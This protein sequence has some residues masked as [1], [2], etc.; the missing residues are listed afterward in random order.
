MSNL[1][2]KG[3]DG[4]PQYWDNLLGM[5]E[6]LQAQIDREKAE[7]EELLS[8]SAL[9]TYSFKAGEVEQLAKFDMNFFAALAVPHMFEV[10]YPPTITAIWELLL[11]Q[12]TQVHKS[13]KVALGIPRG[14]AKTTLIKL[15]ILYVVLYTDIKFILIIGST[16]ANAYN[17]IADVEDMLSEKNITAT[18]GDWEIGQETDTKGLKKFGYRG[19]NIVIAGLGAGGSVRGINIKNTRPDLMI[20]EDV[21]TKECAESDT[22]SSTLERWMI[23]TAMKARAPSG[24]LYIFVGNMYPGPNSI[25]RKLKAN[26]TWI[27]F[28]SGAILADGTALFPAL[29]SYDSLVEELNNDISMGHPEIFFSEVMNDVE[30]GINSNTDLALIRQWPWQD[31]EIPQG[32]FI[33]I[34]PASNRKG[35]DLV[36][37][38]YFEVYDGTPGMKEVIEEP[39]SPGNTIRRALL[40]AMK[41]KVRL[42]AVESTAYQYSL[43]YWF[44]E[45]AGQL[46]ISGISFVEVYSGAYSKNSRI[47]DTLK[48][49]TQ[50]EL[51][52]HN[53]VRAKV[54]NQI[55]NWNPLKRDNVD[56]ILDLL[57]YSKRVM[58]LYGPDI[59]TDVE[60]LVVE[61]SYGET[62][63]L[64]HNSPF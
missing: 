47:Q 24:C 6:D 44:S 48:E 25:L 39:L 13:P 60:G 37:I 11:D 46:G 42:I 5:S 33:I 41:N 21:Q 12:L 26:P 16:E 1:V 27:K 19:R 58:E 49:L 63:V 57:T 31:Y 10:D 30:V 14:H 17:I 53:S 38:G 61:S 22:A 32:K 62:K 2:G 9:T 64:E 36:G 34:D 18:F 8:N 52:L 50:G 54:L 3:I 7:K 20:F 56:N 45:I 51:M 35:G 55:V 40:L 23:G 4:G 28:I 15:F 29:R 43:L 59:T